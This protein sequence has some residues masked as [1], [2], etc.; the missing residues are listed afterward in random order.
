VDLGHLL[1]EDAGSGEDTPDDLEVDESEPEAGTPKGKPYVPGDA[2]VLKMLKGFAHTAR[3]TRERSWGDPY[4]GGPKI[5]SGDYIE[6][7]SPDYLKRSYQRAWLKLSPDEQKLLATW[8]QKHPQYFP[9]PKS[10]P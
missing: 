8:R 5:D 1:E 9:K 7:E 6:P 3:F 10:E 2:E 4:G